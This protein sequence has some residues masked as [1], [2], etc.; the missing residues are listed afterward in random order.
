MLIS[1]FLSHCQT[2]CRSMIRPVSISLSGL[3]PIHHPV[4]GILAGNFV[5]T[6]RY[7]VPLGFG[8]LFAGFCTD[9]VMLNG[10]EGTRYNLKVEIVLQEPSG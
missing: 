1:I 9:F 2:A 3:A 8:E 4:Q 7:V 5:M 10:F 6:L